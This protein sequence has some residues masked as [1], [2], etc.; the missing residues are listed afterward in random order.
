MKTKQL[1]CWKIKF[2]EYPKSMLNKRSMNSS[3]NIQLETGKPLK[4]QTFFSI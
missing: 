3:N 1:I 4:F 2:I